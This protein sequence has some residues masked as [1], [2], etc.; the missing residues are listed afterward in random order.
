MYGSDIGSICDIHELQMKS[1]REF[2]QDISTQINSPIDF[3]LLSSRQI[4]H[5]N[6]VPKTDNFDC[7]N[8]V[9]Y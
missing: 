7:L 4:E 3:F 6:G 8:Q 9:L 2:Q 5:G 1:G